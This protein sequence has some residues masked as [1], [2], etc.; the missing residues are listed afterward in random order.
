MTEFDKTNTGTAVVK[1]IDRAGL[2]D[3]THLSSPY[4]GKLVPGDQAAIALRDPVTDEWFT[5]FRGFVEEWSYRLD[6]TRQYMELELQLVDGF[7]SSPDGQPRPATR[8]R[9]RTTATCSTTAPSSDRCR[10]GQQIL[11]DVSWP[12]ATARHFTGAN[13]SENNS[14]GTSALAA[15][16]D[17]ADEVPGVANLYIDKTGFVAPAASPVSAGSLVRHQRA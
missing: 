9:R 7:G 2:F 16:Q 14:P 8:S 13:L 3:P 12:S 11:N 5:L 4:H 6:Q 10:P 15:L 1:L 17:A